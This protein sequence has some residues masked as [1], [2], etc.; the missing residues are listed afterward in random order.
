[1]KNADGDLVACEIVDLP[2]YDPEK[3]IPARAR[4]DSAVNEFRPWMWSIFIHPYGWMLLSC[5]WTHIR[6]QTS[7]GNAPFDR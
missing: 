3:R 2:F 1:M 5:T 7:S 6:F 4:Q